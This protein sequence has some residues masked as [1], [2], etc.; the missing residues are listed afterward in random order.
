M[1]KTVRETIAQNKHKRTFREE[2]FL[3]VKI[4][5]LSKKKQN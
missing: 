3:L 1:D 5:D 2:H 4:A